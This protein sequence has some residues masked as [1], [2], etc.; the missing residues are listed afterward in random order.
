MVV[1]YADYIGED[2]KEEQRRDHNHRVPLILSQPSGDDV[3]DDDGSEDSQNCEDSVTTRK[4][5]MIQRAWWVF[6]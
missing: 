6:P 2:T 3:V 5:R 4:D 1:V